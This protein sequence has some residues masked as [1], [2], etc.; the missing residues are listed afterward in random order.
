MEHSLD[1]RWRERYAKLSG[2][3]LGS[4]DILWHLQGREQ[5]MGLCEVCGRG[6]SVPRSMGECCQ[7]QA[8]ATGLKA[9]QGRNEG[10]E[11]LSQR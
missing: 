4:C 11:G 8:G 2:T 9:R 10:L 6:F 5:V 1:R 7:V 3:L